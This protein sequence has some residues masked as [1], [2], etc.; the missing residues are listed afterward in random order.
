MS[1]RKLGIGTFVVC[2]L[3]FVTLATF[4]SIQ[5]TQ[6]HTHN[7]TPCDWEGMRNQDPAGYGVKALFQGGV[8]LYVTCDLSS[9]VSR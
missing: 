8:G 4:H 2:F 9:P 3:L 7:L 5:C 6:I 1:I